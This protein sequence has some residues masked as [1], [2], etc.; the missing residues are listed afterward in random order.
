MNITSINLFGM[1]AVSNFIGRDKEHVNHRR[2][3][4]TIPKTPFKMTAAFS[5]A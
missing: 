2:N 1:A 4:L 3:R 5:Y